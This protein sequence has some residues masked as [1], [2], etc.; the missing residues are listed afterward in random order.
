MAQQ[1]MHTLIDAPG[2]MSIEALEK[3][4]TIS[5]VKQISQFLEENAHLMS[6]LLEAPGHIGAIFGSHVPLR[7]QLCIDPEYAKDRELFVWLR[8][9]PNTETAWSEAD[10]KLRRLHSDWLITL[11]RQ[12]TH[13]LYFDLE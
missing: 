11:P 8:V 6:L 9:E 10:N 1:T 3:F 7:L 5:E 2:P 13:D 4:Y 12:I